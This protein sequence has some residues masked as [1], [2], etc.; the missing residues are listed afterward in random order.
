MVAY[1]VLVLT[2]TLGQNSEVNWQGLTALT[3]QTPTVVQWHVLPTKEEL[4]APKPDKLDW[5]V[6]TVTVKEKKTSPLADGYTLAYRSVQQN[7]KEYLISSGQSPDEQIDAAFTARNAS[8]LF[9]V[10]G[11][12]R[13]KKKGI[14][15]M[16]LFNGEVMVEPFVVPKKEKEKVIT[17]DT[18]FCPNCRR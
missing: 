10:D 13:M 9:A 3:E 18:F 17:E 14:Y 8:L 7:G 15:R 5:H 6:V 2:M 1:L 16:F 4:Q 11:K 12:S